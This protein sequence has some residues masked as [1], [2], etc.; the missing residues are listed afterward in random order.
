[1]TNFPILISGATNIFEISSSSS[2]NK[3]LLEIDVE[4]PIKSATKKKNKIKWNK[5]LK[6]I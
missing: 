3:S 4:G 2:T 1:M 6:E 5:L